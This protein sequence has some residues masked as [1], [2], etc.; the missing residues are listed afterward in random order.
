MN[1]RS[2]VA[3]YGELL[4][5]EEQYSKDIAR[6]TR[7]SQEEEHQLIGQTRRGDRDARNKLIESCLKYVTFLAKKYSTVYNMPYMEL[8]SLG[9]VTLVEFLEKALDAR[10]WRAYLAGCVRGVMWEQSHNYWELITRSRGEDGY[11][12]SKTVE[13]LEAPL[14][15]SV[16]GEKEQTYGDILHAEPLYPQTKEERSYGPLHQALEALPDKLKQVVAQW[17]GVSEYGPQSHEDICSDLGLASA[18][19]VR[20]YKM[21][22][23]KALQATLRYEQSILRYVPQ[24]TDEERIAQA[25]TQLAR[26][27]KLVTVEELQEASGVG[28]RLARQY[29]RNREVEKRSHQQ[30]ARA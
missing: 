26:S 4:T 19:A 29:I 10:D 30:R 27:G 28:V 6:F 12:P 16:K 13:S 25:Y 2:Q 23:F 14:Y 11:P 15:T 7:F 22:A 3:L 1:S 24:P 8:V 20:N 5:S 18:G 9:N 17:A 21:R